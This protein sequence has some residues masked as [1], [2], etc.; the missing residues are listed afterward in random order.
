MLESILDGLLLVVVWPAIGYMFLG[1]VI[2][3]YFG[4]VPGLGGLTGMAILLPFTFGMQP[5]EAFAFLLGMYAITTTSDTISSVLLGVPGTAASQATIL[6]GYPMAQKGEAA[7]A[8][9]AAFTV[10]AYGGVVGAILLALSIP[11]VRPLIMSFASPE[12]FMLSLVGL[13]MVG[14]LSGGSMMKG[15][16]A[17]ALGLLL[18]TVG[19]SAEGGVPRY[20][21]GVTYL[22]DGVPLIPFVLG[23]FAVPEIIALSIDKRSISKVAAA[24]SSTGILTGMRDARRHWWLATRCTIIGTYIGLLP[25]LGGSIVDW[26]AYG[27]AVQS[28]KDKSL[29]GKGD[30]RGVIAPEAANNASKGGA[31]IPTIAFAVPGSASMA[32]L[33]VAFQMQGI[34]PGPEMLTTKLDITF[35][36]VWTLVIA[37]IV[38]AGF[39]L[40]WG[41]QVAKLTFIRGQLI[42][43]AITLFVFMGGWMGSNSIGDWITLLLA[44]G[45]GY[46]MKQGGWPRPPIVLGFIL[47]PIMEQAL[48]LSLRSY[49]YTW[50]TRPIVIVLGLVIV[51]TIVL[52]ARGAV[53]SKLLPSD[54][55]RDD[56]DAKDPA[57]SLPF[58]IILGLCFVI[59]I[60]LATDWRPAVRF[61]PWVASIVGVSLIT[62]LI[63]QDIKELRGTDSPPQDRGRLKAGAGFY[64]WLVATLVATLVIGQIAALVGFI[65]IYLRYWGKCSWVTSGVYAGTAAIFLYLMF[66]LLVPVRWYQ[67]L[68][69]F[70]VP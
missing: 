10:S 28:E 41:Q 47:G 2:G 40:I 45:L 21:F 33:L 5:A 65:G 1:L 16:V 53:R 50:L 11:I 60:A 34:F 59:A 6:D 32:I 43:P 55:P 56:S 54:I 29:F 15:L 69:P 23:L 57:V 8:F 27:H 48:H 13:T 30:I 7:R 64:A 31:L 25:G 35:S 36:M 9:G 61:F 52:V 17:A 26:V 18:A 3:M 49:E 22:I 37:N 12:F 20:W 46:V 51:L 39:L 68:I 4:A 24:E 58:G 14:A 19:Y 38:G 63:Y 70:F 44:G 42:V 66:E 62:V 67:P